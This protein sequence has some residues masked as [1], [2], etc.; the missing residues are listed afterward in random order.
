MKYASIPSS[1]WYSQKDKVETDNRKNNPG[2]PVPGYS[3]NFDGTIIPDEL[4]VDAL[5]SYRNRIEFANAGGCKKLSSY[6]LRDYNYRVNHKKVYRLCK[7]NKLLLSKKKKQ[8]QRKSRISQN[9]TITE[10]FQMWQ[11]DLK[12]G[13]IHGE[14]RFFFIMPIIDIYTRLIVDYYVG[15]K[16]RGKD[17]AFTLA[18]A[19]KKFNIPENKQLVVR[20]DN[21]PQMTSKVFIKKVESFGEE[22]VIHELIPVRT[23][24]KNAHIEAFNSILELEFLQPRYFNSYS[25]AY[26]ETVGFI[27][28]YNNQRIHGSLGN[29]TPGQVH[30]LYKSGKQVYL[31]EIKV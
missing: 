17:L 4:I 3:I 19:L 22:K 6:L 26:E 29:K 25:Q 24:N 10:P 8:K 28:F 27:D 1:T 9:Q 14:N 18:N 12:Y 13:F 30:D 15:L 20:S 2:R 5:E 21:G 16:C 11:L 31:P 7:E 23:P